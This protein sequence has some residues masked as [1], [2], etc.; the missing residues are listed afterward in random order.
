[1]AGV[2]HFGER[3]RVQGDA[4]Q[5]LENLTVPAAVRAVGAPA[6]H[7]QGRLSADLEQVTV[8]V[9]ANGIGDLLED[10]RVGGA[11]G[12]GLSILKARNPKQWV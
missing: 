7:H 8:V 12:K 9:R 11:V 4:P 5:Q 1:V 10:A 2:A 6:T 3:Q